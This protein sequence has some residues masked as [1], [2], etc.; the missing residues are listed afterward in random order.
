MK[1]ATYF[2]IFSAMVVDLITPAQGAP[3]A[4]PELRTVAA[5]RQLSIE[6]SRQNIPV[7]LKGVVT[8]FDERLYSYFLQ[9]DTAG[10]Y[11]QFPTNAAY[12]SFRPGQVIELQ[13][14]SSPGEY[15]PVV[16]V[17][18]ARAI[19]NAALP[20][21]KEATYAELASGVDDS[22]FVE[23]TGIVRSAE[24]EKSEYYLVEIVTGE[25]RLLF[26]IKKLPVK[27]PTDLLDSTVRVR[28]VC[29]TKFTR[30]RQLFA[31]Q[32]M[33]PRP[34]DLEITVP[35]PKNPFDIPA[36]PIDSLLQFEPDLTPG[37]R[38]KVVGT[39]IYYVPGDTI[40]IQDAGQ[41]VK[42]Q[43]KERDPLLLGDRIEVLSFVSQGEYTPVLEDAIYRKIAFGEPPDPVVLTPD[44]ALRGNHDCCLIRVT[45]QVL[46]RTQDG[47]ERYLILQEGDSVFHAYLDQTEN[48]DAF[49]TLANG[50]RVAV[51]GVC[52][53]DPGEWYAGESWRA[54]AFSIRLRSAADVFLLQAPSWWTL[55]KVLWM[56]GALALVA[57]AAMAWV[58]VLRRQVAERTRQLEIQIQER[59]R[60]ER[61]REIEQER[62]RVAHD[63]HDDLGAGLTEVNMLSSLVKSPTTSTDEKQRYLDDLADTARRMVTSLDEIVW[64]INSHN[65]TTASLASYFGSYAQRLLDLAGVACGLDIDEKFPELPLDPKFRQEVFFAFKEALT[66]VVRHAHATQ[67][68]LRIAIRDGRL[69]VEV[70]DDGRGFNFTERQAGS[71]GLA[72]MKERLKKLGGE[73]N[74]G[75][76]TNAGTTVRFSAPL[77][78]KLS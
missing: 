68:W 26:Y 78:E 20:P 7:H 52:Q 36:R 29:S 73:C 76:N 69:V 2:L 48:A 71:D 51:T 21:A 18:S 62:A 12:P 56:A 5:L 74:I 49:S 1:P 57:A 77:P 11:L 60:A 45:A 75:S 67:V 10:I 41:G 24:L 61:R 44:E 63:L 72:N 22:Q 38:V 23:V 66:N 34:E 65:D 58:A 50:S 25:G 19:G 3:A 30:K 28:G 9:D 32:M 8:F 53:I 13:G 15:A 17:S 6:Q 54:K 39:V 4:G 37:H 64:A 14:V 42:V 43:T 40:F 55:E 35:A 16:L 47:S 33:A 59:Q 27:H 70:A 46:D 31:I